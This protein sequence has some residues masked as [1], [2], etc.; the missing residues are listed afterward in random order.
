LHHPQVAF[1]GLRTSSTYSSI[2]HKKILLK[3]IFSWASKGTPK[4]SRRISEHGFAMCLDAPR[5]A[6]CSLVGRSK[7]NQISA[8]IVVAKI[9][10]LNTLGCRKTYLNTFGWLALRRKSQRMRR[11]Q[12][13][14]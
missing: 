6:L 8:G 2:D 4:N 14:I 11:R 3:N 5:F 1:H 13:N 9:E 7:S 12:L 10:Y